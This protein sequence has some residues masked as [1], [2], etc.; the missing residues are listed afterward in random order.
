PASILVVD[1]D[2]AVREVLTAILR[3]EGYGVNQAPSADAALD[4]LQGIHGRMPIVL[5]DLKM[6]EHDGQWLLDQILKR[7]PMAAVVMLTGYGDTEN[8]VECLKR[9]ACDYLL[10]PPRITE[11]IRAIERASSRRRLAVARQRCQERPERR[12]AAHTAH[13]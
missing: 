13:A 3:E 12:A 6:P 4:V 9:G 2:P 7:F 8:A 1:D 10:K 11:L 5:S